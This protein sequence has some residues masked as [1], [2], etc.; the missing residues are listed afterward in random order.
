MANEYR[1]GQEGVRVTAS[2]NISTVQARF[3]TSPNDTLS[4][5]ASALNIA[6]PAAENAVKTYEAVQSVKGTQDA[7]G[8]TLAE[9]G[10]KVKSGEMLAS[11]SPAYVAAVQHIYGQNMM[12]KVQ[13]DTISGISRGTVSFNDS[14]SLDKHL[15]DQRNAA[16][17]GQSRFTIAG[18]DKKWDQFGKAAATS[19]ASRLDREYVDAANVQ[20]NESLNGVASQVTGA[21]YTGTPD[22]AAKLLLN[23]H[24]MLSDTGVLLTRDQKKAAW[25][26]VLTNLTESGNVSIVASLLK[27]RTA[28]GTSV[29]AIIGSEKARAAD[30]RATA[31]DD[32]NQRDRLDLELR[33]FSDAAYSGDLTGSKLKDFEAWV[34]KNETYVTT[35]HRQSIL[36]SQRITMDRIE[37]QNALGQID[38]AVARSVSVAQKNVELA[39]NSGTFAGLPDG[40]VLTKTGTEA[41]FNNKEYAAKVIPRIVADKKLSMTDEMSLWSTANVNNPVWVSTIQAGIANLGS[42]GR[43]SEGKPGGTL[44]EQ[45]IQSMKLYS[46]LHR[47]NSAIAEKYAGGDSKTLNDI[48]FLQ[49]PQGGFP[50]LNQAATIVQESRNSGITQQISEKSKASITDAVKSLTSTNWAYDSWIAKQARTTW[51]NDFNE[52]P[53]T[54]QIASDVQR[55]AELLVKSGKVSDPKLAVEASLAYVQDPKITTV[56]N[57]TVYYNANLPTTTEPEGPGHWLGKFIEG[58]PRKLAASMGFANGNKVRL[59]PNTNGGFTGMIGGVPLQNAEGGIVSYQRADIE[60]WI[61]QTAHDGRIQKT[62][63]SN[64]ESFRERMEGS[65]F[66]GIFKHNQLQDFVTNVP[67]ELKFNGQYMTI[68]EVLNV[69]NWKRLSAEGLTQAPIDQILQSTINARKKK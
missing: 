3:D 10:A 14:A 67:N 39:L 36:N 49:S 51:G 66:S 19:N 8:M 69:D 26:N 58:E 59:E 61:A 30:I 47:L 9:L 4:Q 52:T 23:Q 29:E 6:A 24:A 1:P 22:E 53:N 33:P 65:T 43:S 64:Y 20:A 68:K 34:T 2:P 27:S 54:L 55:R 44:N 5:L 31:V 38:M 60:K 40:T 45:G 56:V 46:E 21:G 48:V 13:Q 57:G 50:D 11:N 42:L 18:F 15:T 41:T 17:S 35:A 16:L 12:E 28:D 62:L 63:D 32:K 25:G 37:R 7:S